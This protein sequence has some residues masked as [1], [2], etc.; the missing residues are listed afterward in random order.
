M[1]VARVRGLGQQLGLPQPHARMLEIVA[2]LHDEGKRAENWQKAFNSPASGGP[3][4]KTPGPINQSLLD[5]YRHEFGSLPVLAADAEFLALPDD[6]LRDL[7]LHLVA[8]HHGFARPLIGIQGCA[9]AP[10]SLLEERSREGGAPLRPFATPLGAVGVGLVGVVA[11]C[12]RPASLSG[13]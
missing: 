9:D 10:P 13:T 2:R 8:A 6:E 5:G 3:F 7:A 12:R 11:P 4:A 1:T